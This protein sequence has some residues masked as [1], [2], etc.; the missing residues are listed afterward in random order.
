MV[1]KRDT[2]RT[3]ATEEPTQ[4]IDVY[5]SREIARSLVVPETYCSLA[6]VFPPLRLCF[7]GFFSRVGE[8][9]CFPQQQTVVRPCRRPAS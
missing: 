9:C 8:S 7:L 5:P 4:A 1:G 6:V 2:R 3:L